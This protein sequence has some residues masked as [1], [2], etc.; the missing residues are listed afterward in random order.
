[1]T[2]PIC[3]LI[4]PKYTMSQ[5]TVFISYSHQDEPEKNALL[6]HLGVL[7]AA[8]LIDLWSDDRIRAGAD[9]QQEISQAMAQAQV[10]ILLISANFLSSNFIL[11]TEVATLLRHRERQGLLVFPIIAKPCAWSRVGWLTEMNIRPKHGRPVWSDVGSHA[12]EDLAAIAEEV[13]DIFEQRASERPLKRPGLGE[14]Q[15]NPLW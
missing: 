6:S 8:N 13:A 1:M 15:M 10:A 14:N 5:P 7:Q 4:G 11:N 12:D 9:W 3:P 2:A